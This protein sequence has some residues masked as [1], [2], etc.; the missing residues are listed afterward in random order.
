MKRI[1]LALLA[2]CI[3]SSSPA[4]DVTAELLAFAHT[5]ATNIASRADVIE[6]VKRQNKVHATLSQEQIAVLDKD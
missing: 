2:L 1:R 5:Q 4:D 3:S 6:Q